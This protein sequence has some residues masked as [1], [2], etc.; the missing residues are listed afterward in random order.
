MVTKEG[1]LRERMKRKKKK[2]SERKQEGCES[3]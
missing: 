1:I 3:F 2:R